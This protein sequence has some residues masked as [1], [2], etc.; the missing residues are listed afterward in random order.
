LLK[1]LSKKVLKLQLVEI[2]VK[3]IN[4]SISLNLLPQHQLL[5][6]K[7]KKIKIKKRIIEYLNN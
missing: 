1:L 6:L 2:L 4:L 3:K 7:I 5:E